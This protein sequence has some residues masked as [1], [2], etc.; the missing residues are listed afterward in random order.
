MFRF[1]R[2]I[3]VP[4]LLPNLPGHMEYSFLWTSAM[5]ETNCYGKVTEDEVSPLL[6]YLPESQTESDVSTSSV[7]PGTEHS[8][9][10]HWATVPWLL[11]GRLL[12]G[13]TGRQGPM[14][15][16]SRAFNEALRRF[17]VPREGQ[18]KAWNWPVS[19]DFGG[20]ISI[21]ISRL[22]TVLKRL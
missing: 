18:Q 5:Q 13:V 12:G 1:T 4:D 9:P 16:G 11:L 8:A 14:L 7:L 6:P 15:P 22:F 10:N 2:I 17:T 19:Y 3:K 21:P 20:L